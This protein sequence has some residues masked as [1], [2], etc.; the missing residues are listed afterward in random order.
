MEDYP[1][2]AADRCLAQSSLHILI[3]AAIYK[4]PN[5]GGKIYVPEEETEPEQEFN[6][7][8]KIAI[9]EIEAWE[10]PGDDEPYRAIMI[11]FLQFNS[12]S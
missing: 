7:R 2:D 6:A 12:I 4:E 9:Q 11:K 1:E 3:A 5:V 8:Q 10:L